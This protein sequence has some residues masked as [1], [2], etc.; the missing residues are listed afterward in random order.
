MIL[1]LLIV[2]LAVI[3]GVIGG[4]LSV[5]AVG[6][7]AL[8]EILKYVGIGILILIAIKIIFKLLN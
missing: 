3:V 1:I 4:G 6:T 7:I 8:A 5:L 2:I